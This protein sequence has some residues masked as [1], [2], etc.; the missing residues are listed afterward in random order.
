MNY[1]SLICEISYVLY[2]DHKHTK[3]FYV[4]AFSYVNITN[5]ATAR[6]FEGIYDKFNALA[7]LTSGHEA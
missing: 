4:K 6:N 2:I 5:M 1:L 3:K 7:I